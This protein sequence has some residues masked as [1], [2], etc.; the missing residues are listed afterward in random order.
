[1]NHE[2]GRSIEGCPTQSDKTKS[3]YKTHVQ[4]YRISLNIVNYRATHKLIIFIY[5]PPHNF[6]TQE[7]TQ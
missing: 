6:S 2:D 5:N 7:H 1:M 4:H 3:E